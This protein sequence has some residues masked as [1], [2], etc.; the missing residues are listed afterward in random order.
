MS[1]PC[2]EPCVEASI[3]A[4]PCTCPCSKVVGTW[5]LAATILGSSMAFIDGTVVNVILPV[6]QQET[7]ASVAGDPTHFAVSPDGA[8]IFLAH[9]DENRVWK[10]TIW[11]T[12]CWTP[13]ST[14]SQ[15]AD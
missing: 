8:T 11:R 9:W 14:V 4:V 13:L 6:L 12:V 10:W 1:T 2:R 5:I 15:T 7:G 3:Q